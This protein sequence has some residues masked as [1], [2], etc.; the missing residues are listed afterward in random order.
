MK[1][2]TKNFFSLP[3]T[4]LVEPFEH[5]NNSLS[6]SA[7]SYACAKLRANRLFSHEPLELTQQRTC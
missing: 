5:L 1:P 6:I 2:K 7:Q 4:R 3:T